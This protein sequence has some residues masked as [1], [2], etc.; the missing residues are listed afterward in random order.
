MH[1]PSQIYFWGESRGI[2]AK[3]RRRD[4]PS[5]ATFANVTG[6]ATQTYTVTNLKPYTNYNF[7]LKA[8]NSGGEGPQSDEVFAPTEEAGKQKHFSVLS[9]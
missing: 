5:Y 3:R 4:I 6:G 2:S 1:F 7:A 8:V 9:S